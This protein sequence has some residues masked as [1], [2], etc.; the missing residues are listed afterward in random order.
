MRVGCVRESGRGLRAHSLP[1]LIMWNGLTQ[2]C[3]TEC[4]HR[5]VYLLR[6]D[7]RSRICQILVVLLLRTLLRA[8]LESLVVVS[9]PRRVWLS[10]MSLDGSDRERKPMGRSLRHGKLEGKCDC[11]NERPYSEEALLPKSSVKRTYIHV[12]SFS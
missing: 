10:S 11:T 6:C 5:G 9:R 1:P 4:S 7:C 12:L 8:G 3:L 2:Q